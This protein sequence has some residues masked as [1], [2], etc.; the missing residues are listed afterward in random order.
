MFSLDRAR[1]GARPFRIRPLH[2]L[3]PFIFI[4]QS[5]VAEP[6]T[7]GEALSRVASGDPIL[8]ANAANMDVAKATIAQGDV[9]PRD[10][11]GVE[12]EDFAGTGQYSPFQTSQTTAW[13]E[14]T[15]ERAGKRKARVDAARSEAGVT[16]QRAR[17][18]M[19]DRFA[20]VQSAWVEALAAQVAVGIADQR[21]AAA[22]RSASEVDRRVGRALDPL[23][24][25]ERAR[26]AV[27]EARIARDQARR[28]AEIARANLAAWWGGDS[29]FELEAGVLADMT[30][31]SD[32]GEAPDIAL[33]LAEGQSAEARVRLS[34][35]GN[36]GDP[37]G[38]VG[39]RHFAQGNDFAIMVGGSIPLGNRASNRG[40][41]DRARAEQ[42]AVEAEVAV[43]RLERRREVDRLAA[44]QSLLATEIGRIDREVLPSAERAIALVRDGFAR[45]GTAF[46]FLEINQAQQVLIDARFRRLDLLRRFHLAGVRLDR[47]TGR[48]LPLLASEETR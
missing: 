7:L 46:T 18:R 16:A 9:R 33:L 17:L 26:T 29:N 39:L 31:A 21:L 36:V 24:A 23:F 43:L 11:V 10:T 3:L 2:G 32:A 40:N 25:G 8:A 5:A 12:L 37:T 20:E 47:L 6:L 1:S 15:W 27:A 42:T 38:R 30:L 22:Q 44:E 41:V 4:A 13:Y 14:R 48:H 45:G 28:Q 34:E 35:T 19:L